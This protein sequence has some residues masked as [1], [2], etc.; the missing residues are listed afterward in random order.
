[1]A[2]D[3]GLMTELKEEKSLVYTRWGVGPDTTK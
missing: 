2:E 1:M 3:L